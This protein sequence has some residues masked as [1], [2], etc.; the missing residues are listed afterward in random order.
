VADDASA[1]PAWA[2]ED[3]VRVETT[4]DQTGLVG[5]AQS[6]RNLPQNID[7]VEERKARNLP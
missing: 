3:V 2:Q 1:P 4:V 5:R 6:M 7:G